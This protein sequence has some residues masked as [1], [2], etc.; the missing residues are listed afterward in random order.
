MD[1]DQ[2]FVPITNTLLTMLND[3][4]FRT[5]NKHVVGNVFVRGTESLVI[6]HS[7]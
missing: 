2:I 6:D 5:P 1:N 4:T 7:G 3:Q